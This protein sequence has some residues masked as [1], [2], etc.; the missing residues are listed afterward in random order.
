MIDI[1]YSNNTMFT[2]IIAVSLLAIIFAT[3][4]TI[5]ILKQPT[6]NK[7]MTEISNIIHKGAMTFLKKEYKILLI[8]IIIT[9]LFLAWVIPDK[10]LTAINF[11]FGA[12]FSV[13][14]GNIGMRVATRSN[15]R[16]TQAA[17]NS[18]EKALYIAFSSGLVM[19]MATV[20]IG[21]LGVT[22]MYLIFGNGN[23]E[24]IYGF[25]LGASSVAFFARVGGG[26]YTKS[27]DVGADM[28]G[29]VEKTMPEDDP[30]N[31]AVVAD[32]VG[33]NVGDVAGM[34]A[35]LFESYV[36][37]LIAAMVVGLATFS[38]MGLGA[39]GLIYPLLIAGTGIISSIIGTFFIKLKGKKIYKAID[40][41]TYVSGIL[42]I[43]FSYFI[44]KYYL[45]DS[46]ETIGSQIMIG[47]VILDIEPHQ[48]EV[49]QGNFSYWN[50]L[51]TFAGIDLS[52][53]ARI[54]NE[55]Q[56]GDTEYFG[57]DC[58]TQ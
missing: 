27:A 7:E 9:A 5:R 10:G 12:I 24:L 29:K 35:D 48:L 57:D 55:F 4:K 36:D 15:V 11:I 32:L 41:G 40:K 21:L 49:K 43:I 16:T 19:G 34:G 46:I 30:R 47:S 31:P 14:A 42:M 17:R 51:A 44:T 28:V 38:A 8:F 54:S 56:E 37:S 18:L 13:T 53:E 26:I 52:D 3:I 2:I 45:N 1:T 33:D 58:P 25:G 22:A 39:K 20:G 6:G 50:T 23:P